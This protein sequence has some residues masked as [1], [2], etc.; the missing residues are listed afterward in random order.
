ME[1]PLIILHVIEAPLWTGAVAQTFETALGLRERGHDVTLVTT[2][3]SIL[4]EKAAE[5]GLDLVGMNLRSELNPAAILRLSSII[6]RRRVDVVHAHRAHAHTIGLVA[7][8]LTR[9]P[10]VV[11]RHTALRPRDNLGSR[12][13][14]RARAVTQIIAVSRAVSDVLVDYGVRPDK[15]TVIYDGIDPDLFRTEAL[16]PTITETRAP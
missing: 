5:R 11:S 4:W 1:R 3:G 9:C 8:W 12:I 13:K 14:Y 16:N 2:P 7:A 15:L 6:L 10:F